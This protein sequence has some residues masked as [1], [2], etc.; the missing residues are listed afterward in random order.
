MKDANHAG[1]PR[2]TNDC[3]GVRFGVTGVHDYWFPDFGSQLHLS[4]ESYSL[5]V[6]RRIVVV[7]VESAFANS[8][9]GV[10]QQLAHLGKIACGVE[11]RRVVGMDAGSGEH[12][13]GITCR[14]LAG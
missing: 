5:R 11:L 3:P 4:G 1:G 7:I 9:R 14:Q 12:E 8:D 13:S 6:A 10:A 2:F